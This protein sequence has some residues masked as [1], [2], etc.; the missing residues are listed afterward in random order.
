MER[1][2]SRTATSRRH[3]APGLA[4]PD[5]RPRSRKRAAAGG[6]G[7]ACPRQAAFRNVHVR[8]RGLGRCPARGPS[9]R[10]VHANGAGPREPGERNHRSRTHPAGFAPVRGAPPHARSAR[11][12]MVGAGWR[13]ERDGLA[14]RRSSPRQEPG[15]ISSHQGHLPV[16]EI[17]KGRKRHTVETP[18]GRPVS[19]RDRDRCRKIRAAPPSRRSTRTGSS[20][21]GS[22]E[23]LPPGPTRRRAAYHLA[24]RTGCFS[25]TDTD[26]CHRRDGGS[27]RFGDRCATAARGKVLH[28]GS[29]RLRR[30]GG[31][32]RFGDPCGNRSFRSGGT[33][34]ADPNRRRGRRT[35]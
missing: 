4:G 34:I 7:A 32:W 12:L 13:R 17:G 35:R 23:C 11:P 19:G 30:P 22:A 15:T 18:D 26:S 20:H 6:P 29:P 1:R 27:R 25:G 28:P 16:G 8:C 5:K 21:D 10:A 2:S 9:D 24:A 33:I 31:D 14:S 3:A